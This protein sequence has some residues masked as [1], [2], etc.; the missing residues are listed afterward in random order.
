MNMILDKI[1]LKKQFGLFADNVE[2]ILLK[3][4]KFDKL[5]LKFI[6]DV[7]YDTSKEWHT[8]ELQLEE[9]LVESKINTD[10]AYS[11]I[12]KLGSMGLI[13]ELM[14]K[15]GYLKM[16]NSNMPSKFFIKKNNLG[17]N[18]Y[19]IIKYGDLD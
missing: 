8:I 6:Y 15:S 16:D 10:F 3:L 11:S 17:K 2:E 19:N 18:I 9:L 5:I 12:R 1:N 7:K 14:D 4:T 13:D